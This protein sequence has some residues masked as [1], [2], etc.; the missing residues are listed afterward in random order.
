MTTSLEIEPVM[1]MSNSAEMTTVGG[2]GLQA[3]L[4]EQQQCAVSWDQHWIHLDSMLFIPNEKSQNVTE[5]SQFVT[6]KSQIVSVQGMV[7]GT[8]YGNTKFVWILGGI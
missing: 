5:K 8:E 3:I 2:E 7:G 6:E 1:N 4:L